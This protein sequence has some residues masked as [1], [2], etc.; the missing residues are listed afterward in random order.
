[1]RLDIVLPWG[2]NLGT[3][4]DDPIRLL[5]ELRENSA[6]AA[7]PAPR[8]ASGTPDLTG[9][10]L[11][12]IADDLDAPP[13]QAWAADLQRKRSVIDGS[14]DYP[15]GFC[16]PASAAPV[17]RGFAYKIIQAPTEIVMLNE[18]DTPGHRQIYLDGRPHPSNAEPTWLGYSTAH[19][20]G[21]TLV[22]DTTNFNDR[23]WLNITGVPH[24]ENHGSAW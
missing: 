14:K 12:A 11:S 15:G 9:M 18:N 16:L 17:T 20:E 2:A 4:G 19:W 8:S 7:G 10:W 5:T 22:V 3:A 1:M 21:E 24:T 13:L 6:A 23:A